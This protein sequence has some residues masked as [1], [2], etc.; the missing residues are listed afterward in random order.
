VRNICRML[1]VSVGLLSAHAAQADMIAVQH[2]SHTQPGRALA[3]SQL[4]ERGVDPAAAVQRIDAL[5]EAEVTALDP[6]QAPAGGELGTVALVFILMFAAIFVL[7][8]RPD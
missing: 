5:A 3:Q 2:A 4:V 1:I 8:L 6:A 7:S